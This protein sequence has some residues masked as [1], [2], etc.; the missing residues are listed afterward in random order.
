[1]LSLKKEEDCG[2]D[3]FYLPLQPENLVWDKG[4]PSSSGQVHWTVYGEEW[5]KKGGKEAEN[6]VCV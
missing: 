6:S 4:H 5:E 2:L 1:M 3:L